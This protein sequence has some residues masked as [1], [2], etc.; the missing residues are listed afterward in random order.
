VRHIDF[1]VD[2]FRSENERVASERVMLALLA[3][4]CLQ[5]MNFLK[6]H[7]DAPLLYKSGVR[8]KREAR[9]QEVWQ[10]IPNL[11]R[12]GYGD[13]EDLACWR[14]AELRVRRRVRA[15]PNLTFRKIGPLFRYHVTVRYPNGQVEDPSLK[16]GM[17]GPD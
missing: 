2:L 8:Y 5:N 4:L 14:V 11:L 6:S 1:R 13:C 17:R 10:D 3:G 16:L 15:M 12:S 9:G 7:P